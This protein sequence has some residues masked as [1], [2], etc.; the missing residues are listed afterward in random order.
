MFYIHYIISVTEKLKCK[1]TKNIILGINIPT[2]EKTLNFCLLY[3]CKLEVHHLPF[4]VL[5]LQNRLAAF[6]H[7]LKQHNGTIHFRIKDNLI[8]LGIGLILPITAPVPIKYE[9]GCVEKTML[10]LTFP[11]GFC[12]LHDILHSPFKMSLS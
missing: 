1:N 11:L 7:I 2:S 3:P 6:V 10:R 4:T 9:G 8:R 5:L 12:R